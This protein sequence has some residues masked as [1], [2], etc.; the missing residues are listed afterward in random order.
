MDGITLTRKVKQNI[1]INHTPVILLTAKTQSADQIEGLE[2]GA[3]AYIPKPFNTSVLITTIT[4]LIANREILRNKF[5]G[6]QDYEGRITL[7]SMKSSDEVFMNKVLKIIDENL[8][9]SELNVELLAGR[10][11]MSRVHMHRK[12]KELTN[13]S[14]GDFIRGIRLKQAALML[15]EKKVTVSEVAYA[16]GFRNLSHFSTS[17]K[18][19]YGL[20]PTEYIK[21]TELL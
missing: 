18:D 12:L 8:S 14:A 20:S 1:N 17:F 19:F 13:Q 4:N 5:S 3:D 16:A 11:G 7:P 6:H 15:S 9:N 10:V 2:M 21:K